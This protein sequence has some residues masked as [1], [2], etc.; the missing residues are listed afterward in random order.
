[1]PKLVLFNFFFKKLLIIIGKKILPAFKVTSHMHITGYMIS[2][3][4]MKSN[5]S[6][7]IH[8]SA[9]R[10]HWFCTL[11]FTKHEY[12]Q[13]INPHNLIWSNRRVFKYIALLRNTEFIQIYV[14]ST[15]ISS[16]Y[17][18]ERSISDITLHPL[19]TIR[20]AH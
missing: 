19:D 2:E 20:E 1:M 14:R 5:I 6:F 3:W 15:T 10:T 16:E 17:H 11:H 18:T 12:I 13:R 8:S 7:S 9:W 4:H